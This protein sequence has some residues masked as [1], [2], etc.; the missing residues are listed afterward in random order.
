MVEMIHGFSLSSG[1][2][3]QSQ[4]A[5]NLE[6]SFSLSLSLSPCHKYVLHFF[7]LVVLLVYE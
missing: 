1:I 4:E 7:V 6:V 3:G 2:W 5:S